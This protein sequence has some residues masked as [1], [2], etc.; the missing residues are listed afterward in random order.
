MSSVGAAS[1]P[2]DPV[3]STFLD[4][5]NRMGIYVSP[6]GH[7]AVH[8]PLLVLLML[9]RVQQFRTTRAAFDEIEDALEQLIAEFGR[10]S[11]SRPRAHY[12]FWYLKSD[13]FWTV[14]SVPEFL[15][16]QDKPEPRVSSL[17]ELRVAAGFR[18]DVAERLL[19][20]ETLVREAATRVLGNAFPESRYVDVLNAT[21]LQLAIEVV[22]TRRDAAFR[23]EILRA[24]NARCAVCGYAGRLG[25]QTVGVEA[26][27]IKWVQFGGPNEL[28]NGIALCSLHHK[29]FDAGAF[30]IKAR[31]LQL[32]VS[33]QFDGTDATTGNLID[34]ASSGATLHA[35]TRNHEHPAPQFLDW[36]ASEVFLSSSR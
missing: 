18:D 23:R 9:A 33:P 31:G 36:H 11:K 17:R 7:R 32:M 22:A 25:L 19:A 35:P 24:Y 27:H 3:S 20:D 30:T 8:K 26:A 2:R 34:L 4:D 5:L 15:H 28:P 13:G 6:G 12:P 10:T 1:A 16:R 21:G 14:D 29:L